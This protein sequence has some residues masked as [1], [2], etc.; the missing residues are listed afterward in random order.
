MFPTFTQADSSNGEFKNDENYG[1]NSYRT[2]LRKN[3]RRAYLGNN[4]FGSKRAQLEK[5]MPHLEHHRIHR[6]GWLRAAVMGAN[7]GIV[8]TASLIIGVAAGEASRENIILAGTAG[9]VAGAMSMAAGEYV[10]VKSQADTEVADLKMEADSLENNQEEEQ[11]ELAAIY[12]DRGLDENLADEVARQLMQ[13]D[14]IGAHARDEIGI[15]AQLSARP[16]QAAFWS[17]TTFSIGATIP[18]VTASVAPVSSL[19]W[20]VPIMAIG[21]LGTLGAL[22]ATAGGAAPIRG[23]LR[24]CFWGS[25]AMGLTAAVG[26]LFG[27]IA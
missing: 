24:V 8:S 3:F 16:L 4:T 19:L 17:A 15:S 10:S 9:L 26:K 7:D 12:R 14:A 18:V 25:L 6:S 20:V 2:D 13:H 11:Q 1:S 27:M 23:A 5:K 21:M 22:A